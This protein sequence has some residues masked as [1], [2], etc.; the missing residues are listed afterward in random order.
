VYQGDIA[1]GYDL[2]QE[3]SH[4]PGG[5]DTSLFLG[6]VRVD[7]CKRQPIGWPCRMAGGIMDILGFLAIGFVV[8]AAA[9]I[10]KFRRLSRWSRARAPYGKANKKHGGEL[11][12]EC[13][14]ITPPLRT[15]T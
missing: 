7:V 12:G 13:S 2:R 3:F 5:G 6:L 9:H 1:A 8:F 11:A 4:R 15:E 14:R 10:W